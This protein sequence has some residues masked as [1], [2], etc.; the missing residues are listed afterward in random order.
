MAKS[1]REWYNRFHKLGIME[2]I[3][4]DYYSEELGA[5]YGMD[6]EIEA[7]VCAVDHGIGEY[8]FWGTKGYHTDV[9]PEVN[10]IYVSS[11]TIYDENSKSVEVTKEIEKLVDKW[12]VANSTRIEDA[13]LEKAKIDC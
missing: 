7:N 11:L 10:E 3:S 4:I 9:R 13:I 12:I 8:D 6:I 1:K 5:D 2:V